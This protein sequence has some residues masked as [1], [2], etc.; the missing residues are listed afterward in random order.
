MVVVV[1]HRVV[2][3]FPLDWIDMLFGIIFHC[4]LTTFYSLYQGVDH[5]HT[6]SSTKVVLGLFMLTVILIGFTAN[7]MN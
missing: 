4:V 6:F 7:F 3:A 5:A 2:Y 1:N